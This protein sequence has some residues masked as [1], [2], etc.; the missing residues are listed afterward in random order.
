MLDRGRLGKRNVDIE[1]AKCVFPSYIFV[2]PVKGQWRFL[3]GTFGV[4]G[5]IMQ[6]DVAARLPDKEIIKIRALEDKNGLVVFPSKPQ[7]VGRFKVGDTVRISSGVYSGYVGIYD[8]TSPH[9]REKVLLDYLGRKTR[10]LIGSECLEE[11]L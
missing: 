7:N 11:G 6:G 8:G 9:E 2:R 1:R 10:I 3:L 4:A 5:V